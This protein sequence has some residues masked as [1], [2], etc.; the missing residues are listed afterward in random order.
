MI[1]LLRSIPR[2]ATR[3][4][5]HTVSPD[6]IA[7]AKPGRPGRRPPP[8]PWLYNAP[9]SVPVLFLAAPPDAFRINRFGL[10]AVSIAHASRFGVRTLAGI[11]AGVDAA[12]V[13]MVREPTAGTPLY[14]YVHRVYKTSDFS[15]LGIGT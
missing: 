9:A 8:T 1:D 13:V 7:L 11:L 14:A 6:I 10:L 4:T 2:P 5:D 3:G 12:R 15:T